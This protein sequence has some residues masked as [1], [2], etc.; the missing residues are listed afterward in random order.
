[1]AVML[2]VPAGL[3]L[4]KY[5]RHMYGASEDRRIV[6]ELYGPDLLIAHK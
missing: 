5:L 6:D 4:E 1:M 2:Q 3:I